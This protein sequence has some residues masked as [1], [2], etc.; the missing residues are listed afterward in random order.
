MTSRDGRTTAPGSLLIRGGRVI[1]PATGTDGVMDVLLSDGKVAKTGPGLDA[2]GGTIIEAKGL[3]VAPGFVDVHVHLRE[4]GEEGKETIATGT[5]AAAMGGVTTV[6]AM[7]NTV[8]PIDTP[9]MIAY[10]LSR[11]AQ[12]GVVR[13]R[14]AGCISHERKGEVMAD[15]AGLKEAG[16]V[17]FSDDGNSVMNALLARRAMINTRILNVPYV[18][19]AEDA[20]L[21]DAGVM[22]EGRVSLRLGLAGRSPL[23]EDLIVARD[24][25]LAE[26]TGAHLHVAHV[27]SRRSLEMIREAKARGVPVTC[28]ATPHHLV[29]TDEAVGEF[30]TSAK[31]L[32]PL[33]SEEHRLALIAAVKDGTVDVIASDHAPHGPLEKE[34]EFAQ[35]ASGMVGLETMLPLALE[36]LVRSGAMDLPGLVRLLSSAP[37]RLFH[38]A[39]G[40]LAAGSPADVTVFDP[41]LAWTVD[42]RAFSSKGRNTPFAGRK[43]RGRAVDVIV[44]G[45]IVVRDGGLV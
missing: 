42:P 44:G 17:A 25:L 35:A 13:V 5:R 11:A 22:H 23:A 19:H 45:R 31:V 20:S 14:P 2:G 6:V 32:P 16:A 7:P 21:V 27:S 37:A 4:P 41:E 40:T 39:G 29:L 26:A 24:L 38:L 34:V 30:D 3:V 9:A 15:L 36:V 12:D 1:D 43:V 18:E 28:E 8:P 10:V 33:R